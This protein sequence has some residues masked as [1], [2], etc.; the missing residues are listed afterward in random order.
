MNRRWVGLALWSCMVCSSVM[1]QAEPCLYAESTDRQEWTAIEP[2]LD[3]LVFQRKAGKEAPAI[4]VHVLR[5]ALGSKFTL[6]SLRPL[7]RSLRLEDVVK[8]FINGAVDV[9]AAVNGDYFG[10][11]AKKKDPLGL[12]ISGGQVLWF[13]ANTTSLMVTRDN[14]VRMDRVRMTQ[15]LRFGASTV[16]ISGANRPAEKDELV[17]YSG[18]YEESVP[19]HPRCLILVLKRSRLSVM[20]Q[21]RIH[22][23]VSEV[24]TGKSGVTL[25]SSD[26]A[27]V[28]CGLSM[29]RLREIQE[30][31]PVSI[32]TVLE[33]LDQPVLEAISGGPRILR[34]GRLVNEIR[35][36]GFSLSLRR[37]LPRAHPRTAAGISA[38]GGTAFLL[39]GEGRVPRS[40]G[41]SAVDAACILREAGAS[42]AMLFDGGGSAA[43]YL[44]GKII[45]KP[46]EKRNHTVRTVANALSVVRRLSTSGTTKN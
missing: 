21:S 33:G 44:K 4:Y 35:Q 37:Y 7:G 36:E 5:V 22:L 3:Y 2:G 27:V 41:V 15:E 11:L 30:N 28:G 14:R 45:N 16:S 17:M 9:V 34:G 42:D 46:H 40:H 13:P 24:V 43:L 10:F 8:H 20:T 38:D 32:S 29:V 25:E 1:A 23:Q 39:V 19:P 12:H 18:F 26:L 31:D 6:R